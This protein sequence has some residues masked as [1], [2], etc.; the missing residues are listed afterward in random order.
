MRAIW[1]FG[2][3]YVT[4]IQVIIIVDL[5]PPT[6][7]EMKLYLILQQGREKLGLQTFCFPFLHFTLTI[8]W[9]WAT[10]HIKTQ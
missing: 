5:F 8:W 10:L 4:N 9:V 1:K 6:I 7:D 3:L 2:F